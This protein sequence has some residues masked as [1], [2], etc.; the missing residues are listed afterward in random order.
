MEELKERFLQKVEKTET[1]WLWKAGTRSKKRDCYG[2]FHFGNK[3]ID[4][5]RV[6]YLFFKGEIPDKMYVCHTCD[7]KLCVNPDHLWLG[8]QQQNMQD[9][10]KKGRLVMPE[11]RRFTDGNKPLNRVQSEEQVKQMKIALKNMTIAQ[12]AKQFKVKES[13]VKDLSSGRTY[14]NIAGE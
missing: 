11:G 7:V 10:K 5:H 12:V 9:A 13:F 8:T 2:A 4:A 1:C 14:K 3:V 6:S